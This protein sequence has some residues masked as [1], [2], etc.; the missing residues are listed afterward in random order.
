MEEHGERINNKRTDMAIAVGADR[1]AVGCPF[2]LTMMSDGIKDRN[3]EEKMAARDIAEL[4]WEAMD[5]KE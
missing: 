3:M 5:V 2:C 4:V 1:I